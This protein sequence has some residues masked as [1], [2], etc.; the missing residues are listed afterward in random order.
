M[1]IFVLDTNALVAAEMHCDKHCV[2]MILEYGQLLS[3]AH[4]L[5]DGTPKTLKYTKNTITPVQKQKKIWELHGET[6]TMVS[7]YDP[8]LLQEVWKLHV[9]N[10]KCY[11]ASHM[12]H[13]GA[14]WARNTMGNYR[15]LFTLFNACLA[16]YTHRYGKVHAATRIHAF[17]SGAPKNIPEGELTPFPLSMPPQYKVDDVVQSYQNYYVGDKIRFAKWTNRPVP[18][19]FAARLP[20]NINVADFSRTR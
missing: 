9:Q 15:W 19:W 2:K 18:N 13:P 5:L 6:S 10:S 14:V 17:L 4:R 8:V 3:T 20:E 7:Q 16:E 1:N 12:Q 11:T